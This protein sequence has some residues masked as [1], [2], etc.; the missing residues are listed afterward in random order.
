MRK[1][2]NFDQFINEELSQEEKDRIRR[3]AED[4]GELNRAGVIEPKQYDK[5]RRKLYRSMGGGMDPIN[6]PTLGEVIAPELFQAMQTPEFQALA[7]D[8]WT[9]SSTPLQ[10]FN[11]TVAITT[12]SANR[13]GP[14][15]WPTSIAITKA[16]YVR[17]IWS[18]KGYVGQATSRHE[19]GGQPQV[20]ISGLPGS[21]TERYQNAFR[22]IRGNIDPT[23]PNLNSLPKSKRNDGGTGIKR[24]GV[25]YAEQERLR[26]EQE[27]QRRGH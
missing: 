9:V 10:M 16:G 25:A 12:N 2:F 24:Y 6:D 15:G 27:R 20:M 8:G 3:E 18:G 23:S 1:I 5:F 11:G 19:Q 26:R 17:R 13:N 22:W 4:F 14:N 21:G 7:E